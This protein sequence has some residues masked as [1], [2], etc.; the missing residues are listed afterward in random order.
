MYSSIKYL[1]IMLKIA[2]HPR[3]I[4]RDIKSANIL[5]DHDYEAKVPTK[6]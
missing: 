4:H 3:I 5:L 6:K 2:G 1:K